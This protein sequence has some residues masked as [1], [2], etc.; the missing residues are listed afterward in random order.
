MNVKIRKQAAAIILSGITLTGC[1]YNEIIPS[2]IE[3]KN[4]KIET[5]HEDEISDAIEIVEVDVDSVEYNTDI[6]NVVKADVNTSIMSSIF[7]DGK[8]L[9]TL[10]SGREFILVSDEDPE[11]YAI[12]YYDTYGYVKKEDTHIEFERVVNKPVIDKGYL[13]NGGIIY[14]TKELNG[15]K[16]TLEELEFVEIYADYGDTYLVSTLNYDVGF[17]K[18]EDIT[19]LEGNLAL[20]DITDQNVVYYQDN[21]KVFESPCVSGTIN[22]S[23]ATN[24]GLQKIMSK[25]GAGEIAP[26]AWVECVASFNSDYEGFHTANA[27]RS[28]Y[29]YG[30]DTYTY[31]GSHGCIN[32]PNEEA[33]EL[34]GMLEVGDKTLIKM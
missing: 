7:K 28:E 15:K 26:G 21:N 11:W 4:E 32:M 33:L 29:E 27:W 23:R 14:E 3:M 10:A 20:V 25:W 9:G 19:L 13:P 16:I 2:N 5:I 17:I 31:N 24:L 8:L 30:G 22:T 34:C 1:G 18:K 6:I 12:K